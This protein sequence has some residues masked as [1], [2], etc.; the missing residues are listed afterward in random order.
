MHF[1]QTC[2]MKFEFKYETLRHSYI[3]S[4]FILQ[5]LSNLVKDY[6]LN[7]SCGNVQCDYA[8]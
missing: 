5:H 4:K 2:K 1:I 3:I 7:Q 6:Q 8:V